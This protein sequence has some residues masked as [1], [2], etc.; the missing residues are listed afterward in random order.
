MRGDPTDSVPARRHESR[1][2]PLPDGAGAGA[3]V[4]VDTARRPN[5]GG[6]RDGS[7]QPAR[8]RLRSGCRSSW[9]AGSGEPRVCTA[10]RRKLGDDGNAAP[11][12][13]VTIALFVLCN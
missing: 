7:A 11:T 3:A 8:S 2:A 1:V 10:V 9:W 4:T 6:C 13:V 12:L 5:T